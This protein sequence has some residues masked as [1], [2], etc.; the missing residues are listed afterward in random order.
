MKDE[1]QKDPGATASG[2]LPSQNPKAKALADL[3]GTFEALLEP[4]QEILGHLK[5]QNE[6]LR[7]AR[8]RLMVVTAM[9]VLGLILSAI[10][11][12]RIHV[13]VQR[14]EQT[15]VRLISL[16]DTLSENVQLTKQTNLAVEDTQQK[17]ESVKKD[18]DEKPSLALVQDSHTDKVKVVILPPKTVIH[19]PPKPSSAPTAAAAAPA[20]A[21]SNTGRVLELPVKVPDS[22]QV[23]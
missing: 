21:T 11:I 17:V 4:L 14:L 15:E 18:A 2:S 22:I 20:P 16:K 10:M 9:A 12:A 23:E 5:A 3:S 6:E 13:T 8:V 7:K 1:Q 19:A